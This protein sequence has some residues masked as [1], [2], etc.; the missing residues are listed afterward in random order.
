MTNFYKDN[1]TTSKW[2]FFRPQNGLKLKV[3]VCL[4]LGKEPYDSRERS[5]KLQ[6]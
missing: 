3:V 5:H 6:E 2:T 1:G 4:L